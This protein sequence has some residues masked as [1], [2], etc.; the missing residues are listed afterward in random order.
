MSYSSDPG[1]GKG[2]VIKS[3]GREGRTERMRRSGAAQKVMLIRGY[4]CAYCMAFCYFI[5]RYFP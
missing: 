2:E 4:L 3:R 5:C 1:R